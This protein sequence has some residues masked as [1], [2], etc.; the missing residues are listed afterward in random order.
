M[1]AAPGNRHV[2]FRKWKAFP[3]NIGEW[4]PTRNNGRRDVSA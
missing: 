3:E 1:T 4:H 2:F